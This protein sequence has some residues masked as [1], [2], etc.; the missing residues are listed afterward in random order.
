MKS[1]MDN[2][3]RFHPGKEGLYDFANEHDACGV[4]FVVNINGE[5]S[6]TI[7]EQGIEVLVRLSHRGALGG[8][9]KTGDGAGLLFQIPDEF[10]RKVSESSGFT[11]PPSGEYAVGMIFMPVEK[12][13]AEK[14]VKVIEEKIKDENL[15]LIAWHDVPAKPDCLGEM[16]A[17]SCPLIKQVFIGKGGQALD[18]DAF[19]RKLYVLRRLIEKELEKRPEIG[20]AFYV[21][22]MS[23]RTIVYKGLLLAP[24]IPM[25]YPDLKDKSMKSALAVVHQRYSTNTFPTWRLAHPFRYLAHNGEINT[26]Q[27]N[28]NAMRA[29]ERSFA[30]DCFGSDIK[31]LLP[32]I[33]KGLSDSACLDNA[34]EFFVANDRSLAHTAMMLIPEAWGEKYRLGLDLKGFFEYHAGLMEPWDGPAAVVFS[35]GRAVGASQK[36][37]GLRP[38]RYTITKDGFMV[39]ASEAGVLDIPP[40][41]VEKKGR[42][43]AGQILYVDLEQKRVLFNREI[44]MRVARFLPY[45]RWVDENKIELSGLI[46][47]AVK[48]EM[49]RK[50]LF[51]HQ[52]LFGYTREELNMIIHPMVAHAKEPTGSMGNDAALAVLSE[53]PQLLYAYFKQL[54]AQ[55]TNPPI[56]PI[57]EELVMSLTV[58]IG[59][60]L[61]ILQVT[62]QHA[63]LVKL[64]SPILTDGDIERIRKSQVHSFQSVTLPMKFPAGGGEEELEKALQELIK[65]AEKAVAQ[66]KSV[67]ILSDKN[68]E[69]GYVPIPAL[70]AVSTVHHHLVNCGVRTGTGLVVETGEA[71]EVMHFALLLGYGATAVNPYLVFETIADMIS[72]RLYPRD[73]DLVKAIQNYIKS[74][75]KGL[76]K[77]MSKMGISTLRSYRGAQIF[78]AVGLKN[79]LI[80]KYFAGTVSRINGIGLDVIAKEANSRYLK[81]FHP[82]QGTLET[83]SS[84]G[85]YHYR[86]GEEKHLWTPE[87]IT[88]LQQ[89]TRKN[90]YGIYKEYA[91]YINNQEEHLCTLRGLFKFKEN[92]IPLDEVEPVENIMKRFVTGAMSFGSI[93]KEA[94]E[95]I[96]TAMNRIGA[97]SNSGEGGED[98]A[99]FKT[100]PNGDSLCSSIKQVASARFGVTIEYLV[101]SKELQIKIAQGAKPG[102]GGQLPGHKVDPSIAKVRNATPGV[103]L[104][105][106]PPHH[107]I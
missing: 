47:S 46:D 35:D 34:F 38:A 67:I 51:R 93:S 54:F 66:D 69:E 3:R 6:H 97:M 102:E 11:L 98:P 100:L 44:K 89:A 49:D 15:S 107:D 62:P 105:S 7:I 26:L 56:D 53:K 71:R 101:N 1:E 74:V 2:V 29:R 27:G 70:L 63:Q 45:R 96:A 16:A 59:N 75:D 19:E 31:K 88:K 8:D 78:E 77:I 41:N 12:K 79:E 99:R 10:F 48:T 87:T 95:T 20:E 85:Q 94:H 68:L 9:N 37:N 42:L 90:D 81:A 43:A 82:K 40:E 28:I 91:S 80:E 23:A 30:S 52:N 13:F 65:D 18:G 84:G 55:V 39:L 4:G 5:K 17:K 21:V 103:T 24:Q 22:S 73:I 64:K 14:C 92:P 33:Q 61:N 72:D 76:L 36:R 25:F 86:H 83:L 106:P 60:R 58:F 32:V 57:R 104:I 50:T